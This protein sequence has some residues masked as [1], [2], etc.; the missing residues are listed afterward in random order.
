MPIPKSRSIFG[1]FSR[2]RQISEEATREELRARIQRLI[3]HWEPILG[4]RVGDWHLR[5]MKLYWGSTDPKSRRITF[6]SKLSTMSPSFLKVT[7]VHELVHLRVPGHTDEFYKLMD[8][9]IPGWR[10]L[11]AQYAGRMTP[12]S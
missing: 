6:D 8:Q 11:H 7:V 12:K 9:H 5:D 1:L 4:V 10:R 2:A 3:D